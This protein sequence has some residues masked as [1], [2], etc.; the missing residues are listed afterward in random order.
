[1]ESASDFY[2][3][4]CEK[5]SKVL[6]ILVLK[7]ETDS[8]RE[9]LNQRWNGVSTLNSTQNIHHIVAGSPY[10]I[11]YSKLVGFEELRTHVFKA[12]NRRQSMIDSELVNIIDLT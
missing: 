6:P 5:Q 1:M 3:V 9:F 2:T 10:T 12:Q 4:A 11:R 7:S 8:N